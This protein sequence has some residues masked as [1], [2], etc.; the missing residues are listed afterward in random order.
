VPSWGTNV[1]ASRRILTGRGGSG[2]KRHGVRQLGKDDPHLEGGALLSTVGR[3]P[4][5]VERGL[6]NITVED[7]T[8]EAD[9]SL[10]TFGN[11]FS[12]KYEAICAIGTDR[13]RRIG[14]TLLA[15][16]AGEPLWEAI[17]NAVLAHY[18]GA[19]QTP[20]GEWM[21][22]LKLVL[23]APA[24]RGEYLKINS[25][26]QEALAEAIAARTGTDLE[27]DMYPRILAGAVIATAQVAVRRWS[28]A[29]P[30]CRSCHSGR[31]RGERSSSSRRL[32]RGCRRVGERGRVQ[33]TGRTTRL[34]PNGCGVH[35]SGP[36]NAQA[37]SL[38]LRQPALTRRCGP[39]GEP[40]SV[41]LLT[42]FSSPARSFN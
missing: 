18:E 13:A 2:P 38:K 42:G 41:K 14:V 8:A 9:V 3:V 33:G 25:E 6:E 36:V 11:Y 20:D 17:S 29:D 7:I 31:C 4:T 26:M 12:S 37:G 40:Y 15:R 22:R 28:A 21:A 23:A 5:Y 16:P 19:S 27:Q 39:R 30:P 32:A 34:R 35:A 24:I 1:T 10:R